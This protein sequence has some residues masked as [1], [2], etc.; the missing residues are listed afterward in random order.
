MLIT[1][2]Q[3]ILTAS[4][5]QRWYNTQN[6]TLHSLMISL[7]KE[8]IVQIK[9]LKLFSDLKGAAKSYLNS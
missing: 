9:E 2:L 5:F 8:Y 1:Y 6:I 4:A 3:N 7:Y